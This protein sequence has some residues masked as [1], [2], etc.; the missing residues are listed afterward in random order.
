MCVCVCL[1]VCGWVSG[2]VVGQELYAEALGKNCRFDTDSD[3][4]A[5]DPSNARTVATLRAMLRTIVH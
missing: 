3:N 1:C 5:G 2:L 4:V